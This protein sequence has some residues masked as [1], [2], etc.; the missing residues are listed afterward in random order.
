[1]TPHPRRPR[2]AHAHRARAA[3]ARA[4]P[5]KP[6]DISPLDENPKRALLRKPCADAMCISPEPR[7]LSV[8]R[9]MLPS[10]SG[11]AM[12][13]KTLIAALLAG[14]VAACHAAE[15]RQADVPVSA[16]GPR[17]LPGAQTDGEAERLVIGAASCW[18]GGLWSDAL[19]E[20]RDSRAWGLARTPDPRGI[21]RRCSAVLAHVYGAFD[22]MQYAQLRA[23]EP[24]IVNDVAARV[25]AVAETDRVDAAHATQLVILLRGVADA[26]RENLLARKAADDVKADEEQSGSAPDRAMD[27][28]LAAPSLRITTKVDALLTM[29]AGDLTSE[30]HA[31]G[32][33]CTLDRLEVARRLP[34]H[35]KIY[36]VGGPFVQVFGV[37]PPE[38]PADP[39][40]P[41]RTGTWPGYLVDVSASAGYPV[42]AQATEALDRESLAWGGVLQGFADK[43]RADEGTVSTRTPLPGVLERV[44]ARLEEEHRT[45]LALFEAERRAG[46]Q[47]K[48]AP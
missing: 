39:T 37:A 10:E 46:R 4:A 42:P 22:P 34:K 5:L 19:G 20:Q 45:L 41:I 11:D 9:R 25:K 14:L 31:L 27:K 1:M 16:S 15:P 21:E 8:A 29:D 30:A 44:A 6:H 26:A 7:A 36:A 18:M 12:R 35:L 48:R 13:R 43:L 40:L 24:R 28:A 23:I 38:V 17:P 32:L 3:R 2:L 47:E 33:L